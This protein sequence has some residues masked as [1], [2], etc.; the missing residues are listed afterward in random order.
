MQIKSFKDLDIYQNAY[1]A[2]ILV[3]KKIIPFLPTSEKYELVSQLS[4]SAKAIPPLIAEGFAK[5]H[6]PK[7]FMKYLDDASGECN[8][9]IVHLSFCQDLYPN[10]INKEL[11][12]DLINKYNIIGKQLNK[13]NQAWRN[14]TRK[15]NDQ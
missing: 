7:S 4:R 15:T 1:Q 11:C 14:F 9:V 6:M 2:A 5:K 12:T 13:L 3:M 10:T 8:E